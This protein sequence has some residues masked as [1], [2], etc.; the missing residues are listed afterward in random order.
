ML[1]ACII[2]RARRFD[3]PAELPVLRDHQTLEQVLRFFQPPEGMS[4]HQ[5][6]GCGGSF[7]LD[8]PQK[9]RKKK[10]R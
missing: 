7:G 9:K 6:R 4:K 8:C 10:L 3:V 5:L 2:E 1:I